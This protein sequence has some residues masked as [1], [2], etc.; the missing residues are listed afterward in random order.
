[1]TGP[2]H[3]TRIQPFPRTET[4][5]R[6]P[7]QAGH[8]NELGSPGP[9]GTPGDAWE[10]A[11]PQGGAGRAGWEGWPVGS[12]QSQRRVLRRK[13]LGLHEFHCAV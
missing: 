6:R 5:R 12:Y 4:P 3:Y 13:V 9:S 2:L 7:A 1:M 8:G 11:W 10:A